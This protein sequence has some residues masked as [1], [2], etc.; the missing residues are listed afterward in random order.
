MGAKDLWAHHC[1]LSKVSFVAFTD[2][3]GINISTTALMQTTNMVS[4]NMH[5]E[6]AMYN[7]LAKAGTS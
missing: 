2:F 5:L 3:H 1:V 4:L 6:T 7:W